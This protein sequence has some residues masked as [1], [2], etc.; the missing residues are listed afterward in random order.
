MKHKY[1]LPG[2]IPERRAWFVNYK[3]KIGTYG[4]ALGMSVS[5]IEKAQEWC[6]NMIA[7]IDAADAA[8]LIASQK[9]AAQNDTMDT[10]LALLR[11]A[12]RNQ[13]SA[14]GYN[15]EIGKALGVVGAEIIIDPLTVKTILQA[16]RVHTGVNLKFPLKDC[17][18]GN[19]YCKRKD[20][21]T[22]TLFK[23]I[24][25]PQTIDE[26]PNVTPNVPEERQY[27]VVLVVGDEEIGLA[28]DIV[29]IPV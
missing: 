9:V 12:I 13:K 17:E 29:T 21:T 2:T 27:Y 26:R 20:E 7:G 16:T 1:Y 14:T 24:T 10:N 15:P 4:A 11:P 5:D 18:G 19:I 6:D 23:Y 3:E 22:F 25:H 8:Q 28:S